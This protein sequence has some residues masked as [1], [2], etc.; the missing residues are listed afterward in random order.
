MLQLTYVLIVY[1]SFIV[2]HC[3]NDCI[4]PFVMVNVA[5]L[6]LSHNDAVQC[7]VALFAF[8]FIY[9]LY[10]CIRAVLFLL[11]IMLLGALRGNL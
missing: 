1:S 7:H 3:M 10:T 11:R 9:A 4:V 5:L 2:P 8:I 6:L